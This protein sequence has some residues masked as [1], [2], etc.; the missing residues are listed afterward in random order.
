MAVFNVDVT[1]VCFHCVVIF[2]RFPNCKATPTCEARPNCEDQTARV[3]V[4][5]VLVPPGFAGG[6]FSGDVFL[7]GQ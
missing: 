1:C 5:L 4:V 6:A 3:S 7:Q 2:G